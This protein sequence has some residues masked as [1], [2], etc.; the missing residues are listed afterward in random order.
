MDLIEPEGATWLGN[1][2]LNNRVRWSKAFTQTLTGNTDNL[3]IGA[4]NVVRLVGAGVNLTGMVPDAADHLVWL[5][6]AD[7]GSALVLKHDVTSTAANRFVLPGA[8]DHT[9]PARSACWARY[10]GT[11]SRWYIAIG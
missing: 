1:W 9:M 4:V 3:A 2:N 7:S 6:N 11:T 8:V 10:D 5:Q